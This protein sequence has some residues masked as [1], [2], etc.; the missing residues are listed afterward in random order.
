M[1]LELTSENMKLFFPSWL[2]PLENKEIIDFLNTPIENETRLW[3]PEW[4]K[5]LPKKVWINSETKHYKT[6]KEI[7]QE[8]KL[9]NDRLDWW[10]ALK[11]SGVNDITKDYCDLSLEDLLDE[12][13]KL[14]ARLRYTGVKFNN[15]NLERA[16]MVPI[17]DYLLFNRAGFAKCLWHSEHTPSLHR[18][19]GKNKVYCFGCAKTADVLDVVMKINNC[20]LPEAIKI[21]LR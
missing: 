5:D 19:T 9:I 17:S 3:W 10:L 6:K 13:E 8:I 20:T 4:I 2:K 11:Q 7:K 21:I 15:R 18:I 16:K 12:K 1:S 14:N